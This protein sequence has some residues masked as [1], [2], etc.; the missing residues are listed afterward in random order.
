MKTTFTI[1]GCGSSL[2]VPRADGYWGKC[3]KKNIKNFR[4]RCS[5]LI[6]RG[7]NNILIDT[8]P[9]LRQQLLKNKINNISSVVYTHMHGDQTHGINDLRA[10]SIKNKKKINIYG[11]KETL[12]HLKKSFNYCFFGTREYPSILKS[13]L[14]KKNL[15]LGQGVEKIKIKSIVVKHGIISCIAYIVNKLAYI[16]DCNFLSKSN[17]KDLRGLKFLVIDCLRLNPHPSHFNLHS[18]LE[19]VEIIKPYKIILTNLHTDLDYSFL[20]KNTPKNMIP[21]YDGLKIKI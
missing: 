8:S 20:I 16:S 21:A 14:V 17:L 6:S 12:F 11:N 9:D 18:V 10:F 4:T 1:L 19:A 13:N 15:I 7:K 5:A 2:G 3:S